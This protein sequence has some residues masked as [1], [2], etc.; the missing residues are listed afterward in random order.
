MT[1]YSPN[2]NLVNDNVY[3]KFGF[4]PAFHF[5]IL[6]KKQILTPIKDGI[7]VANLRKMTLYIP[8][9][10]LVIDN[11]F[12]RFGIIRPIHSQDIEQK[13]YSDVDQGR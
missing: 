6:S 4:I 2:V 10:G 3:T 8:N 12:T 9:V 1:L 7:T 13:P 11:V 5:K